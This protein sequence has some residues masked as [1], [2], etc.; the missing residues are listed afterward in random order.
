VLKWPEIDAFNF[1][2]LGPEKTNRPVDDHSLKRLCKLLTQNRI[3][4]DCFSLQNRIHIAG[5]MNGYIV[6]ENLNASN[7]I[8]NR[9]PIEN[10]AS[11]NASGRSFS[12]Q[13]LTRTIVKNSISFVSVAIPI[14]STLPQ[15]SACF[16]CCVNI[17][18]RW[19]VCP[20]CA[21]T[22]RCDDRL[23]QETRFSRTSTNRSVGK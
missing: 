5:L 17:L 15:T 1:D 13:I 7:L 3:V 9:L 18:L 11:S 10:S 19:C 8:T 14:C 6:I 22:L 21:K 23:H 4:S 20:S 12:L 16:Y 2:H